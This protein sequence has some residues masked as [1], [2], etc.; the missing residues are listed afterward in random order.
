[1]LPKDAKARKEKAKADSQTNLD[2]HLKEVPV[3]KRVVPYSDKLFRQTAIEWLVSTD[4]VCKK[5]D[6][7]HTKPNYHSAYRCPRSSQ[8]SR[9][10]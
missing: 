8:V 1:M 10:D 9:D 2:P 5:L 6:L 7:L 3:K 4:Q